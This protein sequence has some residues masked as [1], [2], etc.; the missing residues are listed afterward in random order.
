MR[1]WSIARYSE[2]HHHGTK[3][4]LGSRTTTTKVE[5]EKRCPRHPQPDHSLEKLSRTVRV[6]PREAP[7][8][9][10]G[11]QPIDA[12]LLFKLMILQQLYNISDEELEYQVNSNLI[13]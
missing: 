2:S 4:I 10:A 5:S 9:N 13:C 3:G 6:R 7:Q 1:S 12:I 8:S 11:R